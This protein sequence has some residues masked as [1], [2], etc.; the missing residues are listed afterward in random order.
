M[1]S[2][3]I[4]II[5]H[6]AT[7]GFNVLLVGGHGVG[8][9]A[10]V[11]EVFDKIG[12]TW[13]YFSA[14][15]I[16]PW[17][18]LVGVPKEKDGVLD[19]VRPASIDFEN[20]EAIFLDEYNR[21]PKKVRNACMELIQFGS[22]N[23]KRFPKLK[24]V[25][26][27]VN[28]DDDEELTYDVE[29]LDPA[30][31]D[32]FHIHLPVPNEPCPYYF[33]RVHGNVGHLAVKWWNEQ[34][35]EIKK[36]ISPRRL[37]AG[38]KVF[39]AKGDPQYVFD[40]KRVN[41]GEFCEY[42]DKPDPIELLDNHMDKTDDEKREFL[43]E[44]NT[45]K[46]IHRDL[47]GKERYLKAYAHLMPESTIMRE[48]RDQK[49]SKIVSH[50]VANV[51]RFEHLIPIV[52]K[53]SRAYSPRVVDAFREYQKTNGKSSDLSKMGRKVTIK[54]KEHEVASL[55]F[56]FTG[57]LTG[58]KREDAEQLMRSYGAATSASV[59]F[60][61]THLVT[62][63]KT[64]SKVERAR[65]QGVEILTQNEFFKIIQELDSPAPVKN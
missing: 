62:G 27:A 42:L 52:L 56:C 8:K 22:I 41:V 6:A 2:K 7:N 18:D 25:F 51:T 58:Y 17:V 16:D 4:A 59:T 49:G 65:K 24:V 31:L 47:V 38:V 50:V 43:R 40:P 53:N 19:I 33:K 10:M 13:R 32:R 61:V 5:E 55:C 11:K 9:T 3:E 30:Q 63:D 26:A 46:H 34:T 14:S 35:E 20:L 29:K 64:G 28:P 12:W 48:L 1:S 23:G 21:A 60:Q 36:L 57:K 37:E 45:F 15:T 54:G 44:P 39:L